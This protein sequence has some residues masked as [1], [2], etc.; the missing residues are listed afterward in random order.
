MNCF[1]V[2]AELEPHK[3]HHDYCVCTTTH[4]PLYDESWAADEELLLLE[5][6]SML[7]YSCSCSCY[8]SSSL[9]LVLVLVVMA[10]GVMYLIMLVLKLRNS[11]QNT[12]T[13]FISKQME[14]RV[15]LTTNTYKNSPLFLP[16]LWF[17]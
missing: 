6:V 17:K 14:I 4:F 12:F 15:N 11:V 1:S 9:V 8:C 10:I 16:F 2:G 7:G 5:A 3:S 13:T